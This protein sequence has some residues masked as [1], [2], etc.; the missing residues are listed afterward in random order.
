MAENSIDCIW[1]KPFNIDFSGNPINSGQYWVGMSSPDDLYKTERICLET[2]SNIDQPGSGFF[3]TTEYT[4]CYDCIS[5]NYGIVALQSCFGGDISGLYIY[6]SGLTSTEYSEIYSI[7]TGGTSQ[8]LY[9]EFLMSGNIQKGCYTPVEIA[10]LPLGR[11]EEISLQLQ[12]QGQQ[13][14]QVSF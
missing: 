7:V 6:V 8:P 3:A 2:T 14:L 11:I 9:I 5:N 10:T 4:S 13:C 1:Q 12:S